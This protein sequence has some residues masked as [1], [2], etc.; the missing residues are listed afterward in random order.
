MSVFSLESDKN[1]NQI[2]IRPEYYWLCSTIASCLNL[3]S[4]CPSTG[5]V[6]VL[7]SLSCKILPRRFK[8]WQVG[9]KSVPNPCQLSKFA[10]IFFILQD[11]CSKSMRKSCIAWFLARFLQDLEKTLPRFVSRSWQGFFI[12]HTCD[13]RKKIRRGRGVGGRVHPHMHASLGMALGLS[14]GFLGIGWSN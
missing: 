13:L 9:K 7:L 14:V 8:I 5:P 1:K 11:S 3:G 12:G 4:A 6:K 10:R 2:W